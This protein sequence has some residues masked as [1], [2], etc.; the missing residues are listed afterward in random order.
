VASRG[1]VEGGGSDI[2]HA[3]G[4]RASTSS[5]S[6]ACFTYGKYL[7]LDC[8]IVTLVAYSKKSRYS[9]RPVEVLQNRDFRVFQRH[10]Q[11][12]NAFGGTHGPSVFKYRRLGNSDEASRTHIRLARFRGRLLHL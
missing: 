8:R 10:R 6:Q 11:S 4:V 5:A 2:I 3:V 12:W 7:C 1:M 9:T